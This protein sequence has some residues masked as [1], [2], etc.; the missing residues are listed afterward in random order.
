MIREKKVR[1]K[2]RKFRNF[3]NNIEEW[4]QTLPVPPDLSPSYLGCRSYSFDDIYEDFGDY[5]KFPKSQKRE[6]LQM[7]INFVKA[8]HDLKTEKEKEYRII[9]FLPIPDLYRV[10]VMVGYT[11]AGLESFYAGLNHNG[12]FNKVFSPSTNVQY[13]QNEWGLHIP[14]GLEVK[15]FEGN[16]ESFE[17]DSIWFIGNVN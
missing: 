1:G 4:S 3:R 2:T 17:R 16:D 15:G 5:S 13:L 8:L 7:I 10:L 6:F 9:C 14:D 12:E 11:Q